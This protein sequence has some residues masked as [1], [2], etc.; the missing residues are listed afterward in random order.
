MRLV[1]AN[2]VNQAQSVKILP[3]KIIICAHV[4]NHYQCRCEEV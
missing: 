1:F 2:F 4:L 3:L